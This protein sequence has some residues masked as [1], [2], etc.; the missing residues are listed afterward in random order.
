VNPRILAFLV[1]SVPVLIGAV[2][3][4]PF[5]WDLVAHRRPPDRILIPA[6][7]TGWVRVDFGVKD[8]PPLPRE[9]RRLLITLQPDASLKT[10]SLRPEGFGKDEYFYST[11]NARSALSTSGVC[12]GGMIWGLVT[13]KDPAG[14][15]AEYEK[16]FVGTE[17]QF[18]HEVDPSGKNYSPCE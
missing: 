2:L 14:S 7:Y 18:R 10:S 5:A 12:K 9:Q 8:A 4:G 1:V 16:F 17:D 3:F 13:G 6:G 15:S 11:S